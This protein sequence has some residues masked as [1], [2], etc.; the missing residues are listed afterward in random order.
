[1]ATEQI[2]QQILTKK[3]MTKEQ[4]EERL[5]KERHR[6]GGFISDETLLRLIAS[7][8]GMNLRNGEA[9]TST[10][11][12]A[13]LIA[14]LNSAGLTGRIVAV[15][16]PKTFNKRRNGKFAS[17]L[18]ADKSGI[19]RIVLWNDKTGLVES[20]DLKI[21]QILR[22]S[23]GYTKEGRE[24]VELHVG[25]KCKLETDPQDVNADD[26]P[27]IEAFNTNVKDSTRTCKKVNVQG[28]VEKLSETSTF[29]RQDSTVGKVMRFTLADETGEA[30]VVAWNEKVDE[31]ENILKLGVKLQLVNARTKKAVSGKMEIQVDSGT[32]VEA[33][34]QKEFLNIANLKEGQRHVNIE[35]N[36]IIKPVVKDIKTRKQ[37][38]VKL[39]IFDVRDETGQIRVSAWRKH[40]TTV[41]EI[42]IGDKIAIKDACAKKGFGDQLEI[43]TQDT[44]S[45]TILN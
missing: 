37:E 16:K 33:Q 18:I 3:H 23:H 19:L 4:I 29:E 12:V 14:G 25:E 5:A 2:I 9:T 17:L 35:G 36:V 26:F 42:K 44:T 45:I 11:M 31:L 8:F 20:S 43:S 27:T 34:P 39:A 21:G 28:T 6:A 40:A 13:N 30:Q 38:I 15:F 24:G 1:M 7:E 10:L 32:Y 41:S 22:V